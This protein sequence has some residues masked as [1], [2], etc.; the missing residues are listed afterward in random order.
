M[1][2]LQITDEDADTGLAQ[3]LIA[4]SDSAYCV[5]IGAT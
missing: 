1:L 5:V 4:P 3:T 2:D